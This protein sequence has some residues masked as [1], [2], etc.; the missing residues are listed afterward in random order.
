MM[1]NHNSHIQQP[2]SYHNNVAPPQVTNNVPP[3]NNVYGTPNNYAPQPPTNNY[4]PQN[5]VLNNAAQLQQQTQ[6]TNVPMPPNNYPNYNNMQP[7]PQHQMYSNQSVLTNNNNNIYNLSHQAPSGSNNIVDPKPSLNQSSNSFQH[8]SNQNVIQ[9]TQRKNLPAPGVA[10]NDGPGEPG[11]DG[12]WGNIVIGSDTNNVVNNN[13]LPPHQTNNNQ[14]TTD[15]PPPSPQPYNYSSSGV[16][17]NDIATRPNSPPSPPGAPPAPPIP[18]SPYDNNNYG[19]NRGP[20]PTYL[21]ANPHGPPAPHPMVAP[22]P[23]VGTDNKEQFVSRTLYV[24]NLPNIP[25]QNLQDSLVTYF[26]RYGEVMQLVLYPQNNRTSVAFVE[27]VSG[28]I[29]PTT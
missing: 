21:N 20:A 2:V 7:P 17:I 25:A 19:I 1:N 6:Q 3:P 26:S 8:P 24:T 12:G 15:L 16:P 28:R 4:S 10:S 29:T 5:P 14:Q 18:P 27:Y 13:S 9:M 23:P 22:K 11:Y